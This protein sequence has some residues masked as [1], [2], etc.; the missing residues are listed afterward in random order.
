MK[1]NYL[2]TTMTALM[3]SLASLTLPPVGDLHGADI[4]T[5]VIAGPGSDLGNSTGAAWGDYDND[6]FIDLFVAQR[7]PGGIGSARHF[8]YH[9]NTNGTFSRVTNGPM[10]AVLSAGKG[11]A[12]GDYDNDGYLDLVL[13]NDSQPNYLFHNNGA[14]SF[15]AVPDAAFVP[16]IANSRSVT[17]VD[18]DGDGYVDLFRTA[19]PDEPRRLDHNNHDG[20]FTRITG[21]EFLTVPYGFFGVAWGDYNNDGRPDLFLPQANEDERQPSYLYRND[22]GGM[23]TRVGAPVL[24]GTFNANNAAWGDYDNDGDLDLFVSCAWPPGPVVTRPN[25]FYRNN[26]DGTFTRLTSLPANDPENQGGTS[27]GCKWGD[28][29]NDGWLDLFVANR[30]FQNNFLYHNN[31]DGTFAKITNSIAVHDGGDSWASAWGDY[32]NDGFLDLFVGNFDSANFLYH[33]NGNDNHWLKFRLIGT[34]SNRA[35]IGAKVRVHATINGQTFWQMREVSGGDGT[36]G[37]NSLHV[38]VGLGNAANAD[39]VRIEWP[40]GTVQELH[41]VAANQFLTVTEPG[42]EPRLTA[43][44]ENG[45]AQLTLTGKQ[46]SRYAIETSTALPNWQSANLIVSPTNTSGAVSFPAPDAIPGA[47]RFYRAVLQ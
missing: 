44:W 36:M 7:G 18:Y 39:L 37:Q 9:N 27:T 17:W 12:W 26:G 14:G 28:Y 23:F 11:A 3:L 6:G 10:A 22:G 38:H 15:T 13:V 41:N 31:G 45:Q 21:P 35:A 32:D 46:G 30:L 47:T 42:G 5:K 25:L 2:S 20:T 33:N 40:S 1:K 43:T 29:D 4:F 34:R 16:N 8:L 24:D 19:E